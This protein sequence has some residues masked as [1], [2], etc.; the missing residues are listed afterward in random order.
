MT[1]TNGC[2][3]IGYKT[4]K[5][6]SICLNTY[7]NIN[8]FSWL[9]ISSIVNIEKEDIKKEDIKKEVIKKEDIKKED[10]KKEVIKKEVI[11]KEVI[12]K[13]SY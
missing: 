3:H 13:R 9:K 8:L 1:N 5:D 12:K 10:I 11:K 4:S 6:L 2:K 7:R